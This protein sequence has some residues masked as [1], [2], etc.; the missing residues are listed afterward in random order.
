MKS[1]I[2]PQLKSTKSIQLLDYIFSN[3]IF[4]AKQIDNQVDL[5]IRTIY[6]LLNKL[7]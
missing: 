4:N 7:E 5:N 1:E 2:I 6:K 3:P